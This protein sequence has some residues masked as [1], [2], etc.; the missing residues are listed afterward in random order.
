MY[1][2]DVTINSTLYVLAIMTKAEI[3][4]A[5]IPKHEQS[6]PLT[7]PAPRNHHDFTGPNFHEYARARRVY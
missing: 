7:A 6:T 1:G 2:N 4:N 5:A 3:R